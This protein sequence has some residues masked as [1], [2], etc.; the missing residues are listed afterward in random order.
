MLLKDLK[1]GLK[2]Q[3][4]IAQKGFPSDLCWRSCVSEGDF[5]K[6]LM[7][8]EDAVLLASVAPNW[9]TVCG[10]DYPTPPAP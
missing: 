7:S 10:G 3:T 6:E 2:D 5:A 8:F 4:L 1:N 9:D